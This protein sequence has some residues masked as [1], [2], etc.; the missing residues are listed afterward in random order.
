VSTDEDVQDQ[1]PERDEHYT[2]RDNEPGSFEFDSEDEI[3]EPRPSFRESLS[4][5][6]KGVLALIVVSVAVLSLYVVGGVFL[7]FL[8][9]AAPAVL[10]VSAALFLARYLSRTR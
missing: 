2:D 3:E 5:I 4:E 7:G 6:T 8:T 1:A 10:A 9:W